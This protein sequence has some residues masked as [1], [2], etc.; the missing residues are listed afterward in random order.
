VFIP[1]WPTT[2]FVL[3]A[4]ACYSRG[5][6]KF[7]IWLENHRWFG[8]PLIAWQEH[9]AISW[10]GKILSAVGLLGSVAIMT[11]RLGLLWGAVS[12]TVAAII[13]AYVVSP[14][15]PPRPSAPQP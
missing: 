14:P 9:G 15:S 4:A 7:R 13:I 5:S 2:P 12:L 8:P 11:Y 3:L 10:T 1:L 6:E